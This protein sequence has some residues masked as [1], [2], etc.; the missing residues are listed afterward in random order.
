M[1]KIRDIRRKSAQNLEQCGNNSPLADIDFV[2]NNLGFN[3]TDII[4]GEKQL[5]DAQQKDFESALN[6]LQ[7]GEPVQYIVGRCEFMSLEFEVSPATLIPRAD[8]EILV[9]TVAELCK[10][11]KKISILEVGSGSGCIAISLAYT[12]KS[13]DILSLDI[14]D[15]A[16]TV[17]RRNAERHNVSD[18]VQFEQWDIMDGFSL[19]N[20]PPDVV[21]S[22]PPYIP[23]DDVFTLDRKV[24]DFEPRLALDGGDDGLDFYRKISKEA[25]LKA[26]G[27]LAFEVGINQADDVSRIM[28]ERFVNIKVV[29]DLSG[30]DRVVA[31]WN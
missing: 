9:E 11:K 10:N 7:N 26:D 24:K 25:P 31:G 17:A 16:L 14:S 19:I 5:D 22:N 23:H 4:L 2:L 13:A 8:T 18:R 28:K 15:D 27:I 20:E 6:R 1:V 21:V 12:L 29:K 3:K 30:I